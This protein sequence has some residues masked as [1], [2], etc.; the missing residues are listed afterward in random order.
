MRREIMFLW[1]FVKDLTAPVH[2][3]DD[4]LGYVPTQFLTEYLLRELRA[5]DLLYPSAQTGCA[6]AVLRVPNE[7]CVDTAPHPGSARLHLVLS[8]ATQQTLPAR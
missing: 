5:V 1:E 3:G 7:R 2:L 4:P 8:P 6:A